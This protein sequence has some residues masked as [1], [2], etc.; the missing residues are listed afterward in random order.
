VEPVRP[1]NFLEEIVADD[2]AAGTYGGRVLTR[3]PPEPNGY[4]HIGHAMSICLNFGLA[5]QFGGQ[6]NLRYDDTNPETEREEYARALEDA[7]RWLGFDPA[8]VL[9]TSDY[10]ERLYDWAVQLVKDGKAYVDS[11][12]GEAIRAQRGTVTEPGTDSPF[13][14]R[15]AEESLRLLDEMRRGLHPDG[16]HVLRAKIDMAHPNMKMRDPLMYRI[17]RG[18]PHYRR[19][20]DWAIYPL[21]DWAHGQSDAI[22]GITH[23]LCTLEFDVNRPLY[24]WYL[25][26]IGIAAPRN[27][28][29]EFARLNLDYTV[30][31]KRKLL[32]LVNEGYVSGW[33][34]PRMPTVAGMRRR[35]IRPEALKAFVEAVGVSKVNGRVDLAL[36]EHA[37]RN[38]LN[39][40]AP[41]A[42][43]V[44]RPLKLTLTNYSPNQT[45]V[46]NAPYWPHDVTP[47]E[48]A[49]LTRPLPFS[50]T[51]W[52]EQD[53]FALDPPKGW[54]R[55]SV[56]AEV[57]L[58]H[59]YVIR[60][61]EAVTN[62]AGEVVEVKAT[63]L[64]GTETGGPDEGRKVKGVVHW[65]DALT[66]VPARFRLYDR[67]FA[68][69]APED[70][71]RDAATDAEAKA[72]FLGTLNPYSLTETSGYV[73]ASL[74]FAA[75]DARFQFERLG[76]FGQDPV[77]SREDALVYNRIVTLKDGWAKKD[78][79]AE[80]PS[81]GASKP[82][83]AKPSSIA[84]SAADL[85]DGDA[86]ARFEALVAAGAG[87][88]DAAVLAQDVPLA[89]LF[90]AAQTA[91]GD[92]KTLG[93][94]VA[95]DVRRLRSET[96]GAVFVPANLAHV[97]NLLAAR[98]ISPAGARDV[99]ASLASGGA[100]VDA[101]VAEHGLS[102]VSNDDALAPA[103]AETLAAHPDEVARYR[104]GE[105][106]LLGFLTG[107]AV[108]RAGKGADARRL[109]EL[110]R[111]ALA[112]ST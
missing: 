19:G 99:L 67:L 89:E 75:P 1:S 86:K 15:P 91:G 39:G 60:V 71:G 70:A 21:Y 77:D 48:G 14:N 43:A 17:R 104:A 20:L 35:G 23:S 50:G 95:Q 90:G 11:Q 31:S 37:I 85:L 32:M 82:A 16:A 106:K 98:T 81:L 62:D 88:E 46:R 2:T 100:N 61:D 47:P 111:E 27:R 56:G 96:V 5:Q 26:A 59:A 93:T 38:D 12:D 52:I 79:S 107:Q 109:G 76:F 54:K 92:A 103:V 58:R 33:D 30:T 80:T 110:L 28:Q 44:T 72:A 64:P 112:S 10:F 74:A 3:F 45:E 66:A 51:L 84:V 102:L 108:R 4:P 41:R 65:V 22:E 24:D 63:V 6:T 29:Y 101:I 9:Y 25:D 69:A 105:T 87:R 49:P 34:D 73:E 42:L 68:A 36:F 7:V 97:A 55:M 83:A 40:L 8:A 13:R 78:A 57:R 94:L 18:V 53:D